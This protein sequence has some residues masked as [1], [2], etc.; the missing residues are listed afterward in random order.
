MI[1][2][3][4]VCKIQLR[5]KC[6]V[7]FHL[8]IRAVIQ[9]RLFY[10]KM[11]IVN[12]LGVLFLIQMNILQSNC[13]KINRKHGNS[14]K[15]KLKIINMRLD[16]IEVNDILKVIIFCII[17]YWPISESLWTITTHFSSASTDEGIA[18]TIPLK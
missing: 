5:C 1:S 17:F 9:N 13:K 8:W 7:L 6:E 11:K 14:L 15:K 16:S 18:V 12:I 4:H 3:S 2:N 10:E